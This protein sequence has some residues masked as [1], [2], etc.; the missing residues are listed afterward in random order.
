MDLVL[1]R[2]ECRWRQGFKRPCKLLS[3]VLSSEDAVTL[4]QVC[5]HVSRNPAQ[6]GSLPPA[7][8]LWSNAGSQMSFIECYGC[9][10]SFSFRSLIKVTK[11]CKRHILTFRLSP[12]SYTLSSSRGVRQL[13]TESH[14]QVRICK[15][16]IEMVRHY[17]TDQSARKPCLILGVSKLFQS[18]A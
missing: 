12:L 11:N 5:S 15:P 2:C 8:I 1:Y 17:T 6:T 13:K 4:Y 10:L 14:S 3:L 16:I 9:G 18:T 7:S